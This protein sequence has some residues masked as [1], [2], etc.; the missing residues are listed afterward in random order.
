MPYCEGQNQAKVYFKYPNA[1]WDTFLSTNPP[2]DYQSEIINSNS[3]NGNNGSGQCDC[4]K[5]RISYDLLK[6][7]KLLYSYIQAAWGPIGGVRIYYSNPDNM[8]ASSLSQQILCKGLLSG[9]CLPE[10]QWINFAQ[11]SGTPGLTI[12]NILI[13]RID[14]LPDNCGGGETQ[15]KFTITDSRGVVYTRTEK[16]CPQV[17]VVCGEDK[18]CPS[19]TCE[20]QCG[21]M[22]CCYDRNGIAIDSFPIN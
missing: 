15:C 14:G 11:G 5:Y 7:G 12:A 22:I 9:K 4:I 16:E 6:N 20:C 8:S 19:N 3:S 1:D 21:N 18:K 10:Q 17:K 13:T 2:V